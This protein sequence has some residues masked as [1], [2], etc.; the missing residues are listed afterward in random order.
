MNMKKRKFVIMITLGLL[1][2][3]MILQGCSS[4]GK[5]KKVKLG[6]A[7]SN[8]PDSYSYKSTITTANE[9]KAEVVMLDMVKSYD[10]SYDENNNLIDGYDEHGILNSDKARIIKENTWHNSNIE[11]VMKDVDCVIVPGG[12]DISPNLYK[13]EQAWHG[14][15]SDADYSAQ[16]DV[17]DYLLISYCLDNDIP[18]LCICRGMQMLSIVSG[19]E[20][21]QDIDTYFVQK[22]LS[23]SHMHRDIERKD[24]MS[25]DVDVLSHDSLLYKICKEDVIN[26]CPSW[27]HQAVES[28]DGTDLTV[29][30]TTKT[31]GIEMIEVVERK[32]NTFCI[33]VQYHPEVAVARSVNNEDLNS[34]MNYDEAML[35]FNALVDAVNK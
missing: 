26:G 3:S 12:W 13:N 10:L 19:A 32:D 23:Y 20:M 2:S 7:Y 28:V 17:S 33:G 6:I 31:D 21:I 30:G 8:T 25:H 5:E 1:M 11:E 16:R 35:L 4:E 34:L 24:F 22:N 27:H 29:T 14:L 18:V 15:M 9:T